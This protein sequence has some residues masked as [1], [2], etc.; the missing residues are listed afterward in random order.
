VP[1]VEAHVLA[2]EAGRNADA[3]RL[4]VWH[5][6]HDLLIRRPVDSSTRRM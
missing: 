6:V 3:N 4:G 1:A 5:G 2:K